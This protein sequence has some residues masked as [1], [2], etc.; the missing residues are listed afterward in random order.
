MITT[1]FEA[2]MR[3]GMTLAWP[4][5]LIYTMGC[6]AMMNVL[7]LIAALSLYLALTK[8]FSLRGFSRGLLVGI[9]TV[10]LSM[11]I[12]WGLSPIRLGPNFIPYISL[13]LPLFFALLLSMWTARS[14]ND[15][16][17]TAKV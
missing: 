1:V 17:E 15:G 5:S 2:I 10:A 3:P 8:G 14:N 6:F 16:R 11:I 7:P 12:G 4:L 9:L 13:S